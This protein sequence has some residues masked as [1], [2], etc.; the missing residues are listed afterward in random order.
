EL[1]RFHAKAAGEIL[2]GVGYEAEMIE[3]VR[4]LN[5]K[6]GFPAEA[7]SRTLEDALCLMFLEYQFAELAQKAEGEKVVNA[8][9]KSWKK[10]T[11]RA[12]EAAL[13]LNYN[14]RQ[15]ALL[16]QALHGHQASS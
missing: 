9:Q 8:L 6:E 15:K 7:E 11:E 14:P 16:Q 5:M 1:K 10:M 2:R 13:K 4:A 3:R 12:R